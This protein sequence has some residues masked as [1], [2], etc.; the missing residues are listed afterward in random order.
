MSADGP[1]KISPCASARLGELG[2]LGQEAVA[3]MDRVAR[4]EQRGGDDLL[5]AQIALGRTRR[6]D[7]DDVGR[8]PRGQ[9]ILIGVADR[10]DRL[11]A[12]VAAGPDD[13]NRDLAAVGDEDPTDVGRRT[14]RRRPGWSDREQGLPFLDRDAVL[15]VH[16]DDLAADARLD[17]VHQLHHLD[18]AHRR[19]GVDGRRRRRRTEVDPA[20]ANARRCPATATR[21]RGRRPVAGPPTPSRWHPV[22][23]RTSPSSSGADRSVVRRGGRGSRPGRRRRPARRSDVDRWTRRLPERTSISDQSERSNASTTRL[24]ASSELLTTI[25]CSPPCTTEIILRFGRVCE[26]EPTAVR[27]PDRCG[28][29]RSWREL[30][31]RAI[32][33]QMMVRSAGAGRRQPKHWRFAVSVTSKAIDSIRAMIRSGELSPGERL[34]PE[35]E[36]ADRLGVSRGSLREAVRALSQ[37]NVLDVRRGD[38]TYV[39]SLAPGE[40]LSGMVFAME[41][42]QSQGLEEVVEVRRLLLPPA[43]ALAAQR[44]TEDQ[45][46]ADARRRR[47]A[48]A[49]HRPRR[50]RRGS[51]AGSGRWCR[52]RPATRPSARSFV[53]SSSAAR[54]SAA[55]GSA[56]I[57]PIRD[58][59]LAHQRMLLDAL[60]RGDSDM[61]R[62]IATVQV[63]ERRRWIEQSSHRHARRRRR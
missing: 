47:S 24:I 26:S 43:A 19:R 63:D 29:R 34:P 30:P 17:V 20:R 13:P 46:A 1:T 42:L 25:P 45:L 38:G 7:V 16:G 39:T 18:D 23:R 11:D 40:L 14:S 52:M 57:P 50:D 36:L 60:E 37:I 5:D 35:H 10:H 55:R 58:V 32:L 41:L 53:R 4:R 15:A 2:A 62:S 9:R 27:A 61:A 48:R 59:A 31:L 6:A 44:V 51:I 21:R 56:P 12:L 49:G 3:G 22:A 28:E 54:T 33:K 8:Q